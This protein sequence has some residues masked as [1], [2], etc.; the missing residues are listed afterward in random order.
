MKI[1]SEKR[2][3]CSGNCRKCRNKRK[4]IIIGDSHAKGN[5]TNIKQVLGISAVVIGYVSTSTKLNYITSM[6]NNEINELTKKDAVV[7]WGGAMD[8]AKNEADR[9]LAELS[10]FVGEC[11]YTNVLVVGA[12]KRRDLR[13]SSCVNKEVDKFNRQLH[14]RLKTCEHVKVTDNIRK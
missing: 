14:K 8:I 6:A 9:G 4:I 5:A 3:K 2:S 13:E 10:K 7:I 12:P 11:S 1:N